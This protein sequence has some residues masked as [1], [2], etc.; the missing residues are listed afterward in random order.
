M[1]R[2]G[3]WSKEEEASLRKTLKTNG[4]PANIEEFRADV[5]HLDKL[6]G[7]SWKSIEN[8]IRDIT[9]IPEY[10]MVVEDGKPDLNGK[11]VVRAQIHYCPACGFDIQMAEQKLARE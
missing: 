10:A 7:R 8:K 3:M 5:P 11:K 6:L 1:K 2:K 9:E 4:M